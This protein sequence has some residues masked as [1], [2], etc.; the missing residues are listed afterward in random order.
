MGGLPAE[1]TA[2]EV[3]GLMRLMTGLDEATVMRA[4][5]QKH[6]TRI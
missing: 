6:T 5:R 3:R 4:V 2:N 1:V